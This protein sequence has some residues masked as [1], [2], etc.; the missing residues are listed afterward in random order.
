MKTYKMRGT[1]ATSVSFEL[2]NGK[3]HKPL[4]TNGCGGNLRAVCAL[5]EGRDAREVI[6]MLKGTPCGMKPTSCPDQLAR[7]LEKAI[8]ENE[9]DHG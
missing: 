4:F 9:A 6:G 3:I 1:C 5:I 8:V 2:I 7:A